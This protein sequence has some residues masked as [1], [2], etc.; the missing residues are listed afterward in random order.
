MWLLFRLVFGC[1]CVN[2]C[3][4][5]LVCLYVLCVCVWLRVGC[6]CVLCVL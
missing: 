5:V 3:V 6:M 1:V 2:V 4:F